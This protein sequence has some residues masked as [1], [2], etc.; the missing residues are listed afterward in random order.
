[1]K[2]LKTIMKNNYID[3]III[4]L[5]YYNMLLY[6]KCII[7]NIYCQ[8]FIMRHSINAKI[9]MSLTINDE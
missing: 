5:Y 3:V 8:N 1:M 4:L 2:L 7:Y 9:D 6:Y